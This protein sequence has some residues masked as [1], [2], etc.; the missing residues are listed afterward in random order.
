MGVSTVASY[1]QIPKISN[2]LDT[3]N[4]HNNITTQ[5]VDCSDTF[6]Q[7]NVANEGKIIA[8]HINVKFTPFESSNDLIQR[9]ILVIEEK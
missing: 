1:Q 5:V 9:K 8:K 4:K 3:N 6:S 7:E 2:F